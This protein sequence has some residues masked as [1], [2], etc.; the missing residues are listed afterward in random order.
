MTRLRLP[1]IGRLQRIS[2]WLSFQRYALLLA[3][4]AIAPLLLVGSVVPRI[5]W[6]W[7]LAL[8]LAA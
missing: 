8:P 3:A 4:L 1:E 6:V 5:W 2:L 7:L